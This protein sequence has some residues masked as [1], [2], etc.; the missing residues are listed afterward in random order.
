MYCFLK[1]SRVFP[2]ERTALHVV[3]TKT[4]KIAPFHHRKGCPTISFWACTKVLLSENISAP[5]VFHW[6]SWA[7]LPAELWNTRALG[8]VVSEAETYGEDLALVAKTLP[9]F[10]KNLSTDWKNI[11]DID[12][13]FGLDSFSRF[14]LRADSN[15]LVLAEYDK[16]KHLQDTLIMKCF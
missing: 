8:T 6:R 4:I 1:T 5:S 15:L 11:L 2:S 9:Q 14:C 12:P 3:I 13:E 16:K 7:I 10:S